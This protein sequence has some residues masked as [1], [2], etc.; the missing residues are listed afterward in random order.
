LPDC[1]ASEPSVSA[2]TSGSAALESM[3]M[4]AIRSAMRSVNGRMAK[5]A[6]AARD[7]KATTARC[8]LQRSA[9]QPQPG[10]AAMRMSGGS[11]STQ[12]ISTALKPR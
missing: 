10:G 4:S 7:E 8:A 1:P 6:A 2:S 5:L 3:L 11:A 9:T 12:A